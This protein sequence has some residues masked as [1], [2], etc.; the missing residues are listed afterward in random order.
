MPAAP[1]CAHDP[2]PATLRLSPAD[3]DVAT[4]DCMHR[5]EWLA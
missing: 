2:D 4:V 5:S 3:G 1:D